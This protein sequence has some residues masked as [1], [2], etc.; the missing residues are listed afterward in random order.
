[1]QTYLARAPG[2]KYQLVTELDG[3]ELGIL[4][5]SLGKTRRSDALAR[6]QREVLGT[7]ISEDYQHM[8]TYTVEGCDPVVLFKVTVAEIIPPRDGT[9]V[10]IMEK[11]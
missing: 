4:Y 7:A 11:L 5:G 8:L 1:M 2:G 10:V 9:R 6:T 3:M